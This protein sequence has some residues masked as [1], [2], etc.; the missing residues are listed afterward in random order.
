MSP[1]VHQQSNLFNPLSASTA[2]VTLPLSPISVQLSHTPIRALQAKLHRCV[3]KSFLYDTTTLHNNLSKGEAEGLR[4]FEVRG[5]RTGTC[6]YVR[7]WDRK[8]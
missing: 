3:D 1:L 7:T 4:F 6:T 2:L 8:S 5:W